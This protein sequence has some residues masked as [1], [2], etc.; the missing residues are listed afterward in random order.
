VPLDEMVIWDPDIP[1]GGVDPHAFRRARLVLWKGHCSVHTKF[2]I[3]QVEAF[4]KAH[5]AGK[6]IVH[7]EC[8]F[9]VAKAADAVGSTEFIIKT[10]SDSPEGSVWAVGTEIHLVNRLADQLAPA[11]TVVTLDALGCLCSTMFRVSP[12]HLLWVLEGL[13]DGQVHNP[14]VV[15]EPVKTWAG[16]ALDR[17]LHLSRKD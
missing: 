3:R 1:N 15:P 16:V 9:D 7:P 17:M 14:I 6:V 10:V 8:T 5:P 4:R 11:R 2:S 13:V 12:N